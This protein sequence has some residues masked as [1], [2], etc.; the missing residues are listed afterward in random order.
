MLAMFVQTDGVEQVHGPRDRHR[1]RRPEP[2]S[3]RLRMG[4]HS[5]PPAQVPAYIYSDMNGYGHFVPAI[6][7]SLIYWISIFAAPGRGLHCLRAP[8]RRRLFARA[9][10]LAM[11]RAPA[12]APAAALFF[13]SPWVPAPGIS[14]TRTSST[15]TWTATIAATSS[16]TTNAQFKKY[17]IQPQPKVT[18]VETSINIYPERRSFDASGRVT[19]QNKTDQPMTEIHLTDQHDTVTQGAFRSEVSPGKQSAPRS[20]FNLCPRSAARARRTS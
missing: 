10:Q 2:G 18:A 4:K 20:V 13:C 3:V 1:N 19:L 5:L 16:P 8:R 11:Q 12:L 6:V 17:E 7:W 14:T 9:I 15:N